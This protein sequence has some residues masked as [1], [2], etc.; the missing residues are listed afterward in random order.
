MQDNTR[1]N[2]KDREQDLHEINL[3]MG[4]TVIQ[5]PQLLAQWNA[6]FAAVTSTDLATEIRFHARDGIAAFISISKWIQGPIRSPI[7]L[8]P[9]ATNSCSKCL[10]RP[11]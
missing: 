4:L 8:V 1:R 6:S 10:Y 3:G 9:E 7:Q 2:R 5:R 11:S